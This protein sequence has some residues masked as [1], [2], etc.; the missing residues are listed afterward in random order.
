MTIVYEKTMSNSVSSPPFVAMFYAGTDACLSSPCISGSTCVN[1][2][3]GYYCQ[4]PAGYVGSLCD[5]CNP[6]LQHHS[7]EADTFIIVLQM[8]EN[9]MLPCAKMAAHVW[10]H[11][12]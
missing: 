4:C 7:T 5:I 6:P 9:A 10:I 1:T 11:L 3:G 12:W 2:A 8:L